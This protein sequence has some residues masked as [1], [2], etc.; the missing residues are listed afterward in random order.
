MSTSTNRDASNEHLNNWDFSNEHLSKLR[1]FQW[2]P[3]QTVMLPMST[4][5]NCGASNEHLN[6]EL[7]QHVFVH[8]YE[9]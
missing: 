9:Q 3:Q 4:L 8:K 5:T 1:R 7:P 2:A 6:N